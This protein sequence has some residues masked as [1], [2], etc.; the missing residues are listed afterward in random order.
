MFSE[1]IR[2]SESMASPAGSTLQQASVTSELLDFERGQ[3]VQLVNPFLCAKDLAVHA[4]ASPTAR[5]AR[6]IEGKL[7]CHHVLLHET[8]RGVWEHHAIHVGTCRTLDLTGHL[9]DVAAAMVYFTA[10]ARDGWLR[11]ERVVI[12][13]AVGDDENDPGDNAAASAQVS[14][15]QE[16]IGLFVRALSSSVTLREIHIDMYWDVEDDVLTTLADDLLESRSLLNIGSQQLE[17]HL[18]GR[19]GWSTQ[20]RCLVRQPPPGCSRETLESLSRVRQRASDAMSELDVMA[21]TVRSP[22]D[23]E[24]LNAMLRFIAFGLDALGEA[25]RGSDSDWIEDENTELLEFTQD[26]TLAIGKYGWSA[27]E[28]LKDMF[29]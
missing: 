22:E 13:A 19:N 10:M 14:D 23:E 12:D 21:R 15:F 28:H 5:Q 29:G 9:S 17:P 26:V 6:T 11:L 24:R 8:P 1:R 16:K 25:C 2:D 20:G 7:R 4:C 3:L 27:G 18:C